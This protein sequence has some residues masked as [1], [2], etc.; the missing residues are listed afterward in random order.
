MSGP[1]RLASWVIVT[2]GSR[3]RKQRLPDLTDV[4]GR[5]EKEVGSPR[6]GGTI[7]FSRHGS[8]ETDGARANGVR[9]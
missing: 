3:K 4:L 6:K 7:S 9:E 1:P 5:R 2:A 8:G